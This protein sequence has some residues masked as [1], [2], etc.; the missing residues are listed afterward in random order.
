LLSG[1]ALAQRQ[2]AANRF[3]Y[4]DSSHLTGVSSHAKKQRIRNK[5]RKLWTL[6]FKRWYNRQSAIG[7][8]QSAI[9]N[10]QSAITRIRRIALGV[11]I[12]LGLLGAT[13][14]AQAQIYGLKA[15]DKDG[16]SA[17]KN[18]VLFSITPPAA[19]VTGEF[20]IDPATV[21]PVTIIK[22]GQPENV[23]ADGLAIDSQGNL[24][25]Y[26]NSDTSFTPLVGTGSTAQLVKIDKDT[27]VA[28]AYGPALQDAW[29]AGAAFN[30]NDRLW[31]LNWIGL[32][33]LQID[34]APATIGTPIGLSIPVT[35]A[36]IFSANSPDIAFDT[37]NKAYLSTDN[38]IY[39]LNVATGAAT[40]PYNFSSSLVTPIGNP[41]P[42]L[43]VFNGMAFH[44][45]GEV[46]LAQIIGN[47]RIV[48]STNINSLASAHNAVVNLTADTRT[49]NSGPMDLAARPITLSTSVPANNSAALIGLAL[50]LF[51]AGGVML[52]RKRKQAQ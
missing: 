50:G 1:K 29:I 9:G 7:N 24:F 4:L 32:Q 8:R 6:F 30:M 43:P 26:V 49:E 20:H 12:S 15:Q 44:R 52:R 27:G 23:L 18:S 51:G 36:N 34:L 31:V 5:F 39:S 25:A 14:N 2:K 40:A 11:C 48:Y 3:F 19:P 17:A 42:Q 46:W 28:T 13:A 33:L 21:K 22:N 35:G 37:D 38:S 41:N 47:D 10:R 45:G 16:K